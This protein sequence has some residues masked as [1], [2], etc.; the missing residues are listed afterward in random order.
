MIAIGGL[1]RLG[2]RLQQN[3]PHRRAAL[4]LVILL[5]VLIGAGS[6]WVYRSSLGSP[7]T[8]GGTIVGSIA[9]P[10]SA[11]PALARRLQQLQRQLSERT[12]LFQHKGRELAKI[13][14]KTLNAK[15]DIPALRAQ[16]QAAGKSGD[17]VADTIERIKA[18]L[19]KLTVPLSVTIDRDRTR[20]ALE[21]LKLHLDRPAVRRRL[22][23]EGR[24]IIPGRPGVVV[25]LYD[26]VAATET[27]LRQGRF[28]VELPLET[29]VVKESKIPATMELEHV[30]AS[31]STVYS[32]ADK[33]RDRGFNLKLGASKLDGLVLG[34]KEKLSFNEVVG[35]RTRK[36]GYRTAHV[37][38]RG[39][40]IDGMAG[41]SCQ[42][43]STLFAA[44]FFAG[45]DLVSSRP[46]TIPSSYIKLG[47]DATVAYG[48]T[49]LVLGN[50]Y[51]FP[52]AI[53]FVVS[54]GRV[55]VE[56]LGK[57]RPWRKVE[58]RR[59]IK[60]QMPFQEVKR[61][62]PELPRG[63]TLV[64]Q[65]GVPGF[66]LER[67]RLFWDKG[68]KPARTE[69]RT[70]RYPPTTQFLRCGTGERNPNFKPPSAKTPFGTIK[71][72]FSLAQ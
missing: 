18:R 48:A 50:P 68:P 34:P 11:P 30:L 37:I 1:E 49:D 25:G 24:R 46:H 58:F 45:L 23:L 6:A 4:W 56:I 57:A 9:L 2:S 40:L 17:F 47:L 21:K 19:G 61:D 33:D 62:D 12:L 31:F 27:A 35:P 53:H 67:Q 28:V 43:S 26:A 32:L 71:P 13:P 3:A 64:A 52:V 39:E 15:L 63:I 72:E 29:I 38:Q 44:A 16:L 8:I 69:S 14:L 36:E 41:G 5:A 20:A 51:D 55:T 54:R 22:D 60:E 66:V 70:L 65:R 42:L 10:A 59:L 7:D